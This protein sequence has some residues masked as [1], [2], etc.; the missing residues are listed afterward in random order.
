MH[1][2]L[3]TGG[4]Q[5]HKLT[6]NCKPQI[7][8]CND[9]FCNYLVWNY[10]EDLWLVIAEVY[11]QRNHA[12]WCVLYS[13]TWLVHVVIIH[14]LLTIHNSPCPWVLPSNLGMSIN[15]WLY[16]MPASYTSLFTCTNQDKCANRDWKWCCNHIYVSN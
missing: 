10:V 15:L 5:V 16:S 1:H 3:V 8:G 13:P 7:E 6:G 2:T 9:D 14:K 11:E 4:Y 12:S